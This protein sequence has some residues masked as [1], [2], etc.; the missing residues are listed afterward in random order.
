M[1]PSGMSTAPFASPSRATADHASP[2]VSAIWRGWRRHR[3]QRDA[4]SPP[5]PPA[6]RPRGGRARPSQKRRLSFGSAAMEEPQHEVSAGRWKRALALIGLALVVLAVTAGSYVWR[7]AS[8]KDG[9]PVPLK[10][11]GTVVVD[12]ASI[13]EQ[14]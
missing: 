5:Q 7:G 2:M 10:A 8:S 3:F 12:M 4:D 1:R 9:A 14:E 11:S 13:S 6:Q